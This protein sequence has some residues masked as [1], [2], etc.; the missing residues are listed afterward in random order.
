MKKFEPFQMEI[1]TIDDVVTTSGTPENT[2]EKFNMFDDVIG[3][4]GS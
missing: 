3:D 2:F 1:R 4:F